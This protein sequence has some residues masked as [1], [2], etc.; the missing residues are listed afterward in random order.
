MQPHTHTQPHTQPHT[1]GRQVDSH[2]MN[3]HLTSVWKQNATGSMRCNTVAKPAIKYHF[4]LPMTF[5]QQALP[6]VGPLASNW[7]CKPSVTFPDASLK[8]ARIACFCRLIEL[9]E[10]EHWAFF[11]FFL[12]MSIFSLNGCL[13]KGTDNKSAMISSSPVAIFNH[14]SLVKLGLKRA[15]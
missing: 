11:F 1:I 9:E 13:E 12:I 4:H 3:N 10:F 14:N 5:K 2:F 7:P 15:S 8:V 6:A